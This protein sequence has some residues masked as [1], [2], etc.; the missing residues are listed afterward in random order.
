[1]ELLGIF[2]TVLIGFLLLETLTGR[3][4]FNSIGW[5]DNLL[6]ILSLLQATVIIRPV[7][8]FGSALLVGWLFPQGQNSLAQTPLWLQFVGFLILD[9]MVQYWWHRAAHTFPLLWPLH[10]VHHAAPYLGVRVWLRNGLFYVLLMPN[11]WLSGLLIY[12][13][14]GKV[15]GAYYLLKVVVTAAAHSEVRWDSWLYRYRW[16]HPLAWLVERTISTPATH[17]AHH[18]LHDDDGI[19][20]YKGN[21]SNLLFIWDV[22]FGTARIT[23]QY[24]P[25]F[26][27]EEDRQHGTE[28]WYVQWLYPVFRSQR[29]RAATSIADSASLEA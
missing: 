9:D 12:L 5:Q 11:L 10:R 8:A 27:L 15:Y 2:A 6:D 20:H 23:R 3:I 26:G 19:G 17:F 4:K 29:G 25:A 14:F 13:G 7:V 21:F 28:R 18:A 1:M 24:P 16:L 22:L